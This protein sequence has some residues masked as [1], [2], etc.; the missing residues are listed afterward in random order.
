M[1]LRVRAVLLVA[2]LASPGALAAQQEPHN[3]IWAGAGVTA[4]ASN[5]VVSGLGLMG[6]VVFQRNP[7]QVAIRGLFLQDVDDFPDSSSGNALG[8]IGLLYGRARGMSWGHVSVAAGVSAVGFDPCPNDDDT[9]FTVGIPLVA[10]A[11]LSA[12]VVGLGLQAF[13]HM[14]TKASYAGISLFVQLGWMP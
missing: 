11:A 13:A 1:C 8:E 12:K 3:R 4:G 14:N 6:Q 7:H 2:M 5:N 9:C 10:E